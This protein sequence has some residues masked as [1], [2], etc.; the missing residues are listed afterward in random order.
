MTLMHV[1]AAA[2][3]S[4][5]APPLAWGRHVEPSQYRGFRPGF[6][7]F[8]PN[9]RSSACSGS[10]ICLFPAHV[11]RVAEVPAPEKLPWEAASQL[12]D[13]DGVSV[14]SVEQALQS[15]PGRTNN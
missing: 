3:T 11:R 12:W 2:G 6:R 4:P 13:R 10:A 7:D 15:N 8:G 1:Y 9:P 5:C 14:S